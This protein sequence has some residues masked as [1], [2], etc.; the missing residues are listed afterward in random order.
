MLLLLVPLLVPLLG[1]LLVEILLPLL[2]PLLVLDDELQV[3]VYVPAVPQPLD[4]Q[5]EITEPPAISPKPPED[6]NNVS[7]AKRLLFVEGEVTFIALVP[8][9]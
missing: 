5:A 4:G 7:P 2:D 6:P 9:V 3:K 1:P 8:E